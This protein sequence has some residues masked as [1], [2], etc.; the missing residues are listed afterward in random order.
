ME[1]RHLL[2]HDAYHALANLPALPDAFAKS[3]QAGRADSAGA[4]VL[5][6]LTSRR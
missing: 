3:R 5:I 2:I 4:G 1:E 6:A